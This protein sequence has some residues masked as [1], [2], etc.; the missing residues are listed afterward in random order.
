[1]DAALL[2]IL[3]K[4][5]CY[6]FTRGDLFGNRW[7]RK[8]FS[9][10]HIMP[11]HDHS[12]GRGTLDWNLDSFNEGEQILLKGGLIVFFPEGSGAIECRLKP[13]RKGAFRLALD[14]LGKMKDDPD[15]PI[16]PAGINYTHPTQF[17]ES[18]VVHFGSPIST[19]LF[20]L[21]GERDSRS[22]HQLNT[23]SATRMR[24]LVWHVEDPEDEYVVRLL[25]EI[26]FNSAGRDQKWLNASHSA[27]KKGKFIC[28]KLN[29]LNEKERAK[30]R[31]K[32]ERYKNQLNALECSDLALTYSYPFRKADV[33]LLT[34]G[35]PL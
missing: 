26:S 16:I 14:A 34:I 2:G 11:V 23:E 35:W 19:R 8:I 9:A 21:K 29:G 24:D 28:G 32:C 3:I 20:L 22:L 31:S 7:V 27:F 6:F 33:L 15:I 30:I 5:P 12:E 13:L 10:L 17:Q 25:I 4:R 1:M 18:V